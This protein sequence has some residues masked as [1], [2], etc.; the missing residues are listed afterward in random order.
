MFD[1]ANFGDLLFPLIAE[2]ELAPHG[3]SV[4]PVAATDRRARQTDAPQ[5]LALKDLADE[6]PR[7]S[8]LLVGGGYMLHTH[9][10]QLITDFRDRPEADWAGPGLWLGAIAQAVGAG[11]PVMFNAPGMPHP[12]TSRWRPLATAVVR[13]SDYPSVRDSGSA[14]M[15]RDATGVA[16]DIVPDTIAAI[17]RI[18]PR[19]SL[20]PLVARF[21][22]QHGI[23]PQQG[24]MAV[25]VRDRS[26]SGTSAQALA[27]DLDETA[28]ALGLRVVLFALGRAHDD[29]VTAASVARHMVTRPII[30]D[31]P[32]SLR[33]VA[34]VLAHSALYV[35]AS[36]HGFI[37][38]HAYGVPSWLV[39]RPAYGKF[40][41]Y[42]DWIEAPQAA[43][44]DWDGALRYVRGGQNGAVT[45]LPPSVTEAL[46]AHWRH[47]AALTRDGPLPSRANARKA[48]MQAL[49][50]SG[51]A[52][53]DIRT[54]LNALA[55]PKGQPA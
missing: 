1:M 29:E 39:T 41:G 13:A 37:V 15:L 8:G 23:S 50:D 16:P 40:S 42:L 49:S 53:G 14:R 54:I 52:G 33:M 55:P 26:L 25:H 20:A 10:L 17:A 28:Q 24:L 36:L 21:R 2:A 46:S 35:G 34:A 47:I 6:L 18:W 31:A 32:E 3:I 45:G 44:A 38:A 9:R 27:R 43:C 4:L 11:K 12:L 5:P 48:L 7:L 22:T 30:L 19:Q 51:A